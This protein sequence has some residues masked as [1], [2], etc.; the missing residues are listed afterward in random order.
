[1]LFVEILHHAGRGVETK[2]APA[3]EYDG[4]H[5]LNRVRRIQQVGLPRA[6]R[7]AA[8]IDAGGGARFSNDHGAARWSSCQREMSDFNS[9]NG[10]QRVV[11]HRR[12]GGNGD[13]CGER[14]S[15]A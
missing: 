10:G 6:R 3:R 15:D 4:V 9:G 8:H 7:R 14:N 1:V 2:C 11:A 5:L 12:L 13:A